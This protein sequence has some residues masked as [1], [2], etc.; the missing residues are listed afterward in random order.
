M[1][2]TTK[3][4]AN[5]Y[6]GYIIF[7]TLILIY[8]PFADNIWNASNTTARTNNRPDR[9]TQTQNQDQQQ[10]TTNNNVDRI[11]NYCPCYC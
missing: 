5:N 9:Q 3:S 7:A 4:K 11:S 6:W 2:K 10:A 8:I 1:T